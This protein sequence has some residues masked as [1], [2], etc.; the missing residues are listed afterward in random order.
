MDDRKLEVVMHYNCGCGFKVTDLAAGA[1]HVRETGHQVS[2]VGTIRHLEPRTV[3]RVTRER[4][5]EERF[6]E[7]TKPQWVYGTTPRW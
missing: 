4:K 3:P 2:I 7:D 1:N 6:N 5:R